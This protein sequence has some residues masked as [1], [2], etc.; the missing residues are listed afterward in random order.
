MPFLPFSASTSSHSGAICNSQPRITF[1]SVPRLRGTGSPGRIRARNHVISCIASIYPTDSS[2]GSLIKHAWQ[3]LSGLR[4]PPGLSAKCLGQLHSVSC[5]GALASSQLSPVEP[6][7]CVV[8][9]YWPIFGR[10]S[11]G[12]RLPELG[13]KLFFC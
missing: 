7:G 5:R 2:L 4:T 6:A 13:G 9:H 8:D 12:I 3:R 11:T 10:Y 1:H